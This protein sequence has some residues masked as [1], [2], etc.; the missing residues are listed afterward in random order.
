MVDKADD[1]NVVDCLEGDVGEF[2]LEF[3]K[4]FMRRKLEI[5]ENTERQGKLIDEQIEKMQSVMMKT[6]KSMKKL[7]MMRM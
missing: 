1:L 6:S 3:K 4:K 5:A 7:V 2:L